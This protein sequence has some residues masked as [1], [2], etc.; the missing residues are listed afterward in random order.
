MSIIRCPICSGGLQEEFAAK[1][2]VVGKCGN[3]ACGHLFAITRPIGTGIHEH[4]ESN[5]GLYAARN[6]ILANRLVDIGLLTPRSRILDIGSGLG[7]IMSAVRERLQDCRITCVEAAPK[8]IEHLHRNKFEVIEDFASLGGTG[9]Y[10]LIFM[11][12]VIEHL[13]DPVAVLSLCHSLLAAGGSIFLTTPCGEL[14]W[15]SHS[16]AAYEIREHVQFFTPRS[17]C[18]AAKNAG[19]DSVKYLDMREFYAGSANKAV[20]WLKDSLRIARN[21]VQGRHHFVAMLRK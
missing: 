7:H 18:L 11:V 20:K 19:F 10:D 13:D 8:S 16:T 6:K 4:A 12:E 14:R 2:C 17:L 3:R 5:I 21:W 15:G 1:F 9:P